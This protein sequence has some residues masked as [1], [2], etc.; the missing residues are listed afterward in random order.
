MPSTILVTDHKGLWN[1]SLGQIS[2]LLARMERAGFNRDL[3]ARMR[4]EPDYL[5]RLAWAANLGAFTESYSQ[6]EARLVLRQ[7]FFGAMEWWRLVGIPL[8][9]GHL[10]LID[11]FPWPAELI[12]KPDKFEPEK[13]IWE[14][15]IAFPMWVSTGSAQS[16]EMISL[17]WLFHRFENLFFQPPGVVELGLSQYELFRE[18]V[19]F[20]R[21]YLVRLEAPNITTGKTLTEQLDSIPDG[22]EAAPAL[23]ATAAHLFYMLSHGYFYRQKGFGRC[24]DRPVDGKCVSVNTSASESHVELSRSAGARIDIV[25]LNLMRKLP[26]AGGLR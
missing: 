20:P 10:R 25:G 19:G 17:K 22:Y 5:A 8:T 7:N 4:A 26:E 3:L 24:A 14:T 18:P 1:E 13:H 23:I 21:W 9:Q 6:M 16:L 15:H 2:D 12:D 11:E